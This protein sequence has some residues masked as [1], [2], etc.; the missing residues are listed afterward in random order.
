MDAF[1]G[2]WRTLSTP[3]LWPLCLAPLGL[4]VIVYTGLG[5][6]GWIVLRER[7]E[8]WA[9]A[10]ALVIYLLAFPLA[11]LAL[12]GAFLGLIF[13]PLAGAVD[14]CPGVPLSRG[15]LLRDA[16]LRL[17]LNAALGGGGLVLGI[18]LGPAAPFV[19]AS[20]IGLLDFTAP[21][22]LRRGRTL[23]AQVRWLRSHL[24][25][26]LLLFAASV[27]ALSLA[28]AIGV[29]L[30]PGFVVGGALLVRRRG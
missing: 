26:D 22:S 27:G 5:W 16:A 17:G 6:V 25:L 24:G 7:L 1:R 18:W 2:I 3:R 19:A 30:A 23:G 8:G 14:G 21:S 11:F 20:I 15:A 13:E 29:L 28:P 12:C 9:I 10:G 4:A